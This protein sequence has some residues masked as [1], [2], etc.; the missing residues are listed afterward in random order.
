MRKWMMSAV[1]SAAAVMLLAACGTSTTTANNTTGAATGD[2]YSQ[3]KSKGVITVGTEGTYAPFDYHDPSGKLV[4]FD[5]DIMN[6]VA[7]RLGVKAQYVETPWDGM[8]AGLNAKRFDVI[9]DEVGIL[10][11]RQ[12]QYDFSTPYIA[13]HAVLIVRQDNN[14]IHSFADLKGKNAGQSLTSNLTAIAR[15]NGANI[16]ATQGFN[17]AI[18]LLKSGRIDATVNDGLSFLDLKKHQPNVPLK[19]VATWPQ[20]AENGFM[21]RKGNQDLVQAVDKA[22]ADMKKDGTYLKISEKWFGADVSK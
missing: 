4:G 14:T 20:A 21:F 8:F 1:V 17:E 19:V 6:E 9:A 18:D 2:L 10:P 15:Q 13:S 7:H 16:V 22:L 12:K 3:I 5:I 11:D